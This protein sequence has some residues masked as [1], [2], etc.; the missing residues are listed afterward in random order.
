PQ[1][2]HVVF[3]RGGQRFHGGE[4][5][6]KAVVIRQDCLGAR[7]LQHDLGDPDPVRIGGGPPRKLA[8][9]PA[10]PPE[11]QLGNGGPLHSMT[12][13]HSATTAKSRGSTS[14]GSNSG[15]SGSRRMRSCSHSSSES[16]RLTLVYRLTV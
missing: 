3:G 11:E 10:V 2:Q 15:F 9:P 6:E 7:L 14:Q 1:R 5:I 13:S 12:R 8:M 16:C 4:A